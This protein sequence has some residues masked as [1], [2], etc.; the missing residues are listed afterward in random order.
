MG[1]KSMRTSKKLRKIM[2]ALVLAGLAGGIAIGPAS[3]EDD[4]NQGRGRGHGE[5][6]WRGHEQEREW[7]EQARREHYWREQERREH[8]YVYAPPP[9][10]YA[11]PP[12][13]AALNFVFPLTIR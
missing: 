12:P 2:M 10:Y 7:R 5:R 9:V 6:E 1:T 4:W 8:G 13:P 11:P 3:A